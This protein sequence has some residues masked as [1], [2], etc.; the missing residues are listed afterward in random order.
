MSE[1]THVADSLL[2]TPIPTGTLAHTLS[3]VPMA[4]SLTHSSG[5]VGGA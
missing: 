4:L 1:Y 5:Q 3:A 2:L